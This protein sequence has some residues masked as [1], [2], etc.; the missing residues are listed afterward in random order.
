MMNVPARDHT[1]LAH[2]P[3]LQVQCIVRCRIPTEDLRGTF[4]LHYYINNRD[5]EHH[6]AI[7]Y[8]DD[9]KSASLEVERKGETDFDR[10]ARGASLRANKALTEG[11]GPDA[12]VPAPLAEDLPAPLIRIHSACFTGETVGSARCDCAEQLQEAMRQ[13]QKEGRGVIVYLRQEGRGIGLADKMRAYNLQDLGHDTVNA[14]LMLHL[15]ADART[16]EIASLILQDLGIDTVRL[17]TNN[18]EKIQGL[19][20][21][22]LKIVETR[23]MIPMKWKAL[24]VADGAAEEDDE[25]RGHGRAGN[26]CPSPPELSSALPEFKELDGYLLTKIERMGHRLEVPLAVLSAAKKMPVSATS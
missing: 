23:S 11:D 25:E 20:E 15:P 17:L 3:P 24:M 22:G 7:V 9:L 2:Q 21:G 8:G 26:R 14:N 18:P 4:Y 12:V 5:G 6:M 16:Y 1:A 19:A 10:V 13:I